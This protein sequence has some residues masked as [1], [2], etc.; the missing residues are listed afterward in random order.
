MIPKP[1]PEGQR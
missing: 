1:V